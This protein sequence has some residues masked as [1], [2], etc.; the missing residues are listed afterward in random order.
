MKTAI[1]QPYFFPYIGYF[2]L[3][4][5]TDKFVFY[6][7]VNFKKKGWIHRNNFL[8]NKETSL[9]SVPLKK[10]S[11]NKKINETF[12]HQE[13]FKVWKE[14]FFKSIYQNYKDSPHFDA[15]WELLQNFFS[16]DFDLISELSAESVKTVSKHL[17][18]NT[19]FLYSSYIE[20]KKEKSAEEK[21]L[22]INSILKTSKYY[23]LSGGKNLYNEENFR[24]KNMELKFIES[25]EI[26]YSQ[27]TENFLPNLSIIDVLMYNSVSEIR[28][29]L[30]NYRVL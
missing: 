1:M 21:I 9:L 10:A 15:T 2:Q 26:S 18:I 5:T 3:V 30:N 22:N 13:N 12:I 29:M 11:Q 19:N 16:K 6:D 8:I 4:N 23:N 14:K 17:N 7:D 27:Q 20:Y 25:K 24:K 28:A